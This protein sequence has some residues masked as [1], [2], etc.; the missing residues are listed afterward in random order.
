MKHIDY[1]YFNIYSY[2]YR[3]SQ[4]RQSFN[5]RIQAMYL[6]SL[7]SGGWL[8]LLESLY[9]HFVKHNRF[10]SRMESILFALAIYGLTAMLFHYIFIVKDR[11]QKI[12]DKFEQKTEENPRRN[13]HLTLSL[14]ILVL[15]YLVMMGL[16]LFLPRHLV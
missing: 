2:C 1:L 3:L 16:A 6:F 7:G 14:S 11:D 5:T 8:L 9:L 12:V 4:Y 15:P 13:L 10:E